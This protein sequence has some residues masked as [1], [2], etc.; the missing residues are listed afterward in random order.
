[1]QRRNKNRQMS[2]NISV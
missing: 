2:V 1:M